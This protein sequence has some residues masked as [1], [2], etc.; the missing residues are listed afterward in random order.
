MPI[1]VLNKVNMYIKLKW[2]QEKQEIC[3]HNKKFLDILSRL[4]LT[5]KGQDF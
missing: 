1:S 5:K 3:D 2:K 4:S